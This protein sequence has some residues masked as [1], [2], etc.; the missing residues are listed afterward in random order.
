MTSLRGTS[1][2]VRRRRL[3]LAALLALAMAAALTVMVALT[4]DDRVKRTVGS[5][6]PFAGSLMPTGVR[7]PNFVLRDQDGEIFDSRRLR[8]DI[9]L[10]TFVYATCT[11]S[12]GPQLQLV[13]GALDD[14][15]RDIPAVA[16]SADPRADTPQRA[17][18]FP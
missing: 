9:A 3:S 17:R 7:A 16:I 8:G 11:E 15:G 4:S 6:S 10:I 14:L 13:R 2:A 1:S 18:R 12:C 5:S